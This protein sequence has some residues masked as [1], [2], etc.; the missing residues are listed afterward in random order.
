MTDPV[1]ENALLKIVLGNFK[2]VSLKIKEVQVYV[3]L[4]KINSKYLR[5]GVN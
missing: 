2:S 1:G 4:I 5:V 3:C